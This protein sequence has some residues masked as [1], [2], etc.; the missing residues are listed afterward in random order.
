MEKFKR[1][2]DSKKEN[3]KTVGL[4]STGAI[5][6]RGRTLSRKMIK[7]VVPLFKEKGSIDRAGTEVLNKIQ[8]KAESDGI[9]VIKSKNSFGTSLGDSL[10]VVPSTSITLPHEL[11]H[12]Y[13]K[14]CQGSSKL[15]NFLHTNKIT[16]IISSM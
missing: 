16:M 11:G 8:K 13:S 2:V 4:A 7:G 15:G 6:S 12:S 14:R 5:L 3:L 9:K 1:K 10:V